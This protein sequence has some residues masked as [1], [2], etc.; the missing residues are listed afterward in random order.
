GLLG[1]SGMELENRGFQETKGFPGFSMS[2]APGGLQLFRLS[3]L[4]PIFSSIRPTEDIP[5][6][7]TA[8]KHCASTL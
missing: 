2:T 8:T 6:F 4:P 5:T 3:S 1:F 7:E